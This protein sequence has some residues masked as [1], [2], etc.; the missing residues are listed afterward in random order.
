MYMPRITS[1]VIC[2][3]K[4]LV[5]ATPISGPACVISVPAASRVIMDP[6]TLQIASVFEPFCFASRCA[7]SV[8]AVSPDCEMTTVKRIRLDDGVA[9][10]EFASV[11]HLDRQPRQTFND[12][13]A[14]E[15][16]MPAGTARHDFHLPEFAEFAFGNVRPRPER[17]ARSPD[18]CGRASCP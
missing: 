13:F 2:E 4:A 5:E 16:R 14:G 18:Q 3:V 1:A 8:S 7:A 12:E 15:P 9:V 6:T 10:A 17:R 11:I